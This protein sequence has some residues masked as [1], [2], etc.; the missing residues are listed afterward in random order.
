MCAVTNRTIELCRQKDIK[1]NVMYK[2]HTRPA[3]GKSSNH[4]EKTLKETDPNFESS[5]ESSSE[6]EG[7]LDLEVPTVKIKSQ[8]LE[9][10]KKI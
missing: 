1:N 2:E 4:S 6:E 9:L 7:K 8:P 5:T 10:V 3:S